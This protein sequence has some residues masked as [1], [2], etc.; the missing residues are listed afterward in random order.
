MIRSGRRPLTPEKPNDGIRRG[1]HRLEEEGLLSP[2]LSKSTAGLIIQVEKQE[3]ETLRLAFYFTEIVLVGIN[4]D[5]HIAK[6]KGHVSV[7]IRLYCTTL[8]SYQGVLS[9]V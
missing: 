9:P 3:L 7:C 1:V 5:V 4:N 2:V 8:S 6:S